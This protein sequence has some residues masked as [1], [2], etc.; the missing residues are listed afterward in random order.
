VLRLP[1]PHEVLRDRVLDLLDE[2]DQYGYDLDHV[3][4]I[5]RDIATTRPA[6]RAR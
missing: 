5:V 4:D 6:K 2:A 1:D 3:V